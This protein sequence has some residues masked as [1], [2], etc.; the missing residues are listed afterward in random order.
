MI[1]R[2]MKSLI[3]KRVP[4]V[5]NYGVLASRNLQK[6]F[7]VENDNTQETTEEQFQARY[8]QFFES[9]GKEFNFDQENPFPLFE[10]SGLFNFFF[11]LVTTQIFL[12][13]VLI[14]A[15][16]YNEYEENDEKLEKYYQKMISKEQQPKEKVVDR[17]KWNRDKFIIGMIV[18]PSISL[19]GLRFASNLRKRFFKKI[20]Y[21]PVNRRFNV[22]MYRFLGTKTVELDVADLEFVEVE[23]KGRNARYLSVVKEGYEDYQRV[24]IAAGR[25]LDRDFFDF[26]LENK[27]RF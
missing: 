18:A 21:D 2:N 25:W 4:R 16:S 26:L 5:V 20:I 22:Q 27:T 23:E 10:I 12:T 9:L 8:D 19:I 1:L 11:G 24:Q 3:S 7:S 17:L 6:N 15:A 14:A 13:A